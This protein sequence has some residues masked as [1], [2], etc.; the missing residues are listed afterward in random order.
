MPLAPA[1]NSPAGFLRFMEEIRRSMPHR[2]SRN[3]WSRLSCCDNPARVERAVWNLAIFRSRG[4]T[5][6]R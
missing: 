6:R 1:K 5:E 3:C 2:A 4:A